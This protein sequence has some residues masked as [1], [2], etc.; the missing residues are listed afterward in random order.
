MPVSP[1][2]LRVL[3]SSSVDRLVGRYDSLAFR[4][5][6]HRRGVGP[7]HFESP[8][9]GGVFV[10]SP[11]IKL[12]S[13]TTNARADFSTDTVEWWVYDMSQAGGTVSSKPADPP[14]GL[15]GVPVDLDVNQVE[16]FQ[17]TN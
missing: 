11:K 2:S 17:P 3:T 1:L 14:W 4:F 7:L 16:F 12:N 13:E 9:D 8:G 6:Q 5:E 10:K 15:R